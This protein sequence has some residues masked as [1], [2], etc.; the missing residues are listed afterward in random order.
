[1]KKLIAAGLI[2]ALLICVFP[3]FAFAES[4]DMEY[5]T[6]YLAC[7]GYFFRGKI[8]LESINEAVGIITAKVEVLE[9]YNTYRGN[10]PSDKI[11]F[12]KDY[13]DYVFENG[14]VFDEYLIDTLK[15]ENDNG[16]YEVC[17]LIGIKD[18]KLVE[19][20]ENDKNVG[21]LFDGVKLCETLEEFKPYYADTIE[22]Y[23]AYRTWLEEKTS[24]AEQRY[25][26]AVV[27]YYLT[28]FGIIV[29]GVAFTT[30]AGIG[31]TKLV[32]HK[33]RNKNE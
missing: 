11:F 22:D 5:K 9:N 20:V 25:N 12:K 30:F 21:Y 6:Q 2:I 4:E 16:R 23:A 26:A 13:A 24:G 18:G 10:F 29:G 15:T 3:S 8:E 1:M 32:N 28:L 17:C 27:K 31:I 33:K 14:I 19:L 7:E